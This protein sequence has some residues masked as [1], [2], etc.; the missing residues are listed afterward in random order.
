[1]RCLE[2]KR[3]MDS[4]SDRIRV[5]TVHGA[6]GLE[7]PIVILPDCAK[8]KPPMPGKLLKLPDGPVLWRTSKPEATSFDARG[9]NVC[10][11]I[12]SDFWARF[13]ASS[14][15]CLTGNS[16]EKNGSTT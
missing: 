13:L 15:A 7:A 6:K 2:I 8:R 5:M 12:S 3:Q 9:R 16:L 14:R 10:G 4:A 1:M 11:S